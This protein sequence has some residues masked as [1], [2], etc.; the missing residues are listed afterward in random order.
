MELRRAVQLVIALSFAAVMVLH[1][2]PTVAQPAPPAPAADESEVP[3][4]NQQSA[5]GLER[6]TIWGEP[7][8]VK[9]LIYVID[10]DGVDS[11]EQ[12]FS[13]SVY[14]EARWN[15]PSLRHDGPGPLIRRTTEVWTPNLVLVN[16]QQAWDAYPSFVEIRPNGDVSFRQKTWGWF[17]QPL[18]LHDF[19]F[20]RQVLTIHL[21]AAAALEEDQLRIVPIDEAGQHSNIAER[22]SVPDFKVVGWKAEARPYI[23]SRAA[24]PKAGFVMQVEIERQTPYYI[25]KIILPLCFIVIMSWIPRWMN[26]QEVGTN[27]SVS[28]TSFFTLIAYMFATSVLL[29][30]VPY[31]T[32]LDMFILLSTLIVFLSLLQTVAISR[33]ARGETPRYVERIEKISRIAY[34]TILIAVLVFSFAALSEPPQ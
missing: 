24:T 21:V 3:L 10:V 25:G 4:T 34:P 5:P 15:S 32:R 12:R 13:A 19:P 23:A 27:I 31:L 7:T 11:A 8:E 28:V 20:D 18:D 30:R 26:P 17:S 16:Q 22:F 2:K 1:S 14:Y 6:P 33:L 9:I 29:P